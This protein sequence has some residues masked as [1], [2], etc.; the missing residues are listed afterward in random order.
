MVAPTEVLVDQIPEAVNCFRE[1]N[2]TDEQG[3]DSYMT[4]LLHDQLVVRGEY[5]AALDLF[6]QIS[7]IRRVLPEG[8]TYTDYVDRVLEVNR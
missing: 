5:T 7:A 2:G 3:L 1:S 4:N 8:I 6:S